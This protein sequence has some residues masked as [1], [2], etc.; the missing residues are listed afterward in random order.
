MRIY[1][2]EFLKIITKLCLNVN[3]ANVIPVLSCLYFTK[4]HIASS[5]LEISV[6]EE[7]QTDIEGFVPAFF[8]KDIISNI[9]DTSFEIEDAE[10]FIQINTSKGEYKIAKDRSE[11]HFPTIELSGDKVEINISKFNY[12]SLVNI[13]GKDPARLAMTGF[14]LQFDGTNTTLAATNASSLY[15]QGDILEKAPRII[16]PK[17][18]GNYVEYFREKPYEVYLDKTLLFIKQDSTLFQFRLIDANY[19]A[20]EAVIPQGYTKYF[21]VHI[22]TLHT[23]IKRLNSA[24]KALVVKCSVN[25]DCLNLVA[26][27]KDFNSEAVETL[28]I[29][30]NDTIVFGLS[31]KDT[32]NIL[33][34]C[35]QVARFYFE[36]IDR[37]LLIDNSI[38]RIIQMPTRI[39]EATLEPCDA[40]EV[41][42]V[43]NANTEDLE[44]AEFEE[45]EEMINEA[46]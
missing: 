11:N 13:L 8:L 28:R 10:T 19:P 35:N 43:P 18:I 25:K 42:E 9:N 44:D 30:S 2:D 24:T 4:T 46:N 38:S 39:E 36:G 12:K 26:I 34:V 22:P 3:K 32:L 14:C 17:E 40:P 45:T 23:A 20:V 1:K 6:K 5:N 16:V 33:P 15:I 41:P 37:P 31:I 7:F 21:E 29:E 27:N